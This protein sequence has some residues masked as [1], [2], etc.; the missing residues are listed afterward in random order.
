MPL[1]VEIA[2]LTA[3]RGGRVLFRDLS[4]AVEAG[5][6]LCVEGAN[7]SGKTSLL[8]LIAGFLAPA[9]G[10]IRI[11][12]VAEAEERGKLVGWLGHQDAVKP[13]MTVRE[14]LAFFAQLYR[15]DGEV[16]DAMEAVGLAPLADLP[17]QYLS[18]GQKKRLALA[19]LSLCDRPV[20]LIDEPL[21][22][23]DASG[24]RIAAEMIAAHCGQGGIALVATH[25]PLGV[26]C[27]RLSL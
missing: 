21:A 18:A 12:D 11:G 4:F 25:E 13:Q 7:G 2:S 6:A 26:G 15:S 17:G 22:S 16:G 20:W 19:R 14:T 3:I 8:R 24:K 5:E 27:A 9:A 23:L 10:A 1:R